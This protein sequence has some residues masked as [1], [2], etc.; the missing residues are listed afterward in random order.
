MNIVRCEAAAAA[1]LEVPADPAAVPEVQAEV[2]CPRDIP[3]DQAVKAAVPEVQAEV[4]EVQ[5]EEE[6]LP[7]IPADRAGR[8]EDL[9]VPVDR[10]DQAAD[11]AVQAARTPSKFTCSLMSPIT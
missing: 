4:P 8:G 9:E 7:D 5:A 10:A 1:V 11:P 6:C 2:E 3:A